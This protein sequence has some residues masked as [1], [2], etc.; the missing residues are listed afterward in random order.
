[1]GDK[2]PTQY[3][4]KASCY[5]VIERG[6]VEILVGDKSVKILGPG[7][8][9]GELALLYNAPRSASVRAVTNCGFWILDRHSFR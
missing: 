8:P 5:F 6:E 2:V 1:M 9:F 3:L 7:Q 4:F